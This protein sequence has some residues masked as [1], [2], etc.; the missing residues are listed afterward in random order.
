M[1]RPEVSVLI[2]TYNSAHVISAC[3]DALEAGYGRDGELE[4]IVYDNASTDETVPLIER[5]WPAV[6]VIAGERNLG[7]AKGVNRAAEAA[8]GLNIMLLNPDAV[9]AAADVE[10]LAR[11]VPSTH[12]GIVAPVIHTDGVRVMAAG[13]MPTIWAM[14]SHYFGI[15]RL[16]R[17][18]TRLQGH[19]LLPSDV[20]E[21]VVC[22]DWVTGA[23]LMVD[24]ETWWRVGGLTERWFMYAEDIEFCWRVGS[25][26]GAV[27][28]QPRAR[29][30]HLVGS[31]NGAPEAG[32]NSA[33][34]LNL[35]EFYCADLAES[36]LQ[37]I[38]WALV[39]G[40]GLRFRA[41]VFLLQSLLHRSAELHGAAGDF[42]RHS[43]A[44]FRALTASAD[45]RWSRSAR[46]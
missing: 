25:T 41:V 31:S 32:T 46:S 44:V 20:G 24:S 5:N 13:R 19:Y 30:Q 23:C 10:V 22:T 29:A 35:Y 15:S 40:C 34:V 27:L 26:G 36:R 17:G 42:T 2:V 3:L 6:R 45:D 39:V 4:I 37:R 21:G 1:T 9:I 16:S 43:N 11:T 14:A 12:G 8:T 33:W 18:R 38:V 28:I 7:F